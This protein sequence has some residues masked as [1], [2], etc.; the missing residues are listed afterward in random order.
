MVEQ[1]LW[2]S[3]CG[4]VVMEELWCNSNGETVMA[5]Q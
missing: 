1:Y 5:E 3:T 2:N 4:T